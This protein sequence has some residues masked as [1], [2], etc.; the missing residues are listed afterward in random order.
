MAA[1]PEYK[2]I[3][4]NHPSSRGVSVDG[5]K[6]IAELVAHLRAHIRTEP[7]ADRQANAI[8]ISAEIIKALLEKG[9]ALTADGSFFKSDIASLGLSENGFDLVNEHAIYRTRAGAARYDLGFDHEAFSVGP[10]KYVYFLK[11]GL[12]DELTIWQH[13]PTINARSLSVAP[14]LKGRAGSLNRMMR[15]QHAFQGV[16]EEVLY[17]SQVR[18]P[19]FNTGTLSNQLVL[20]TIV[21][22]EHAANGQQ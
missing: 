1:T 7:E 6:P 20:G 22:A 21:Q 17:D 15:L 2:G 13:S 10:K 14:V 12:L 16:I 19:F 5:F 18:D 4:V 11:A 3:F 8:E 9:G